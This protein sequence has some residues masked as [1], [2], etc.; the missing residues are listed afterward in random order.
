MG[1]EGDNREGRGSVWGVR[2]IIERGEGDKD[3]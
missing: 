3:R 1:S 2:E